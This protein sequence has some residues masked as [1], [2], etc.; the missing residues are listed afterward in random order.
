MEKKIN[1]RYLSPYLGQGDLTRRKLFLH[2]I[3]LYTGNHLPGLLR[4][5]GIRSQGGEIS[6][7]VSGTNIEVK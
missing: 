2:C 7:V 5:I 1:A 4:R 6:P 3:V